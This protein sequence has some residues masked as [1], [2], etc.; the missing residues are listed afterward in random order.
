MLLT[1]DEGYVPQGV[2]EWI[3]ERNFDNGTVGGWL[4][5]TDDWNIGDGKGE[6]EWGEEKG[7][8]G[9]EKTGGANSPVKSETLN[10]GEIYFSCELLGI[11]D[12]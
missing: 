11:K 5:S 10:C 12:F 3:Y 8:F 4:F 7:N 9:L 2:Y 1:N 6:V